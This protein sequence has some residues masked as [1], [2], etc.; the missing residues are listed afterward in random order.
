[1]RTIANCFR[2]Q[3]KQK[4]EARRLLGSQRIAVV[5][6]ERGNKGFK[7]RG[8]SAAA[9]DAGD[10]DAASARP[11]QSVRRGAVQ[12]NQRRHRRLWRRGSGCVHSTLEC[13]ISESQ[14]RLH[15]VRTSR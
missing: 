15:Q 10:Q 8:G 11:A 1:M 12:P 2:K 3:E 14:A 6:D 5:R 4:R 9:T 7:P 13:W